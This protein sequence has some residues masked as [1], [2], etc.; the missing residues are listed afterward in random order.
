MHRQKQ[1][2]YYSKSVDFSK[3]FLSFDNKNYRFI[4]LN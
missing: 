1:D 3:V 4:L 2:R